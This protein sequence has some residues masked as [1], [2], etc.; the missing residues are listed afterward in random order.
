MIQRL[1][2]KFVL[3]TM[4]LVS[5]VLLAVLAGICLYYADSLRKDSYRAL[6]SAVERPHGDK[7]PNFEIGGKVPEGFDTSPIFVVTVNKDGTANLE[8]ANSI[9]VTET[10]LQDIVA[11]VQQRGATRGELA[12]YDLR[13]VVDTVKGE[14]KI[15]FMA[16]SPE[17]N[18]VLNL[19][20]VTLSV[21]AGALVVFFAASALLAKWALLPVEQAWQKQRRFVADASHELKTPLTVILANIGIVKSHREDRVSEQMAWVQNTE[22]EARRMK[23]LVDDLLFL[24]KGDDFAVSILLQPMNL[25]DEVSATALAFEPVAFEH[26][27]RLEVEIEPE[28][29]LT[30]NAQQIRQLTGILLDNA[31]KYGKAG[32]AIELGLHCQQN[33]AKL[34]VYNQGKP[35]SAE[36]QSHLFERFYRADPSRAQQGYGLGLSIAKTIV[37]YHHG[38]VD[39][40]SVRNGTL[41]TVSLPVK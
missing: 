37:E 20:L 22:E 14:E 23:G 30:G 15:A 7:G 10:Q 2:R 32:S 5:V 38:K 13:Y 27:Y 29:A 25:S 33:L 28:I 24:A 1:R 12:A 4:S 39:V 6:E 36:E 8:S 31:V 3:I 19:F 35:L 34:S 18:R 16:L 21:V 41:F 11:Q 40:E 9:S 26:G 17:H